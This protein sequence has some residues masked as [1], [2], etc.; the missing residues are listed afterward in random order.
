MK[1]PLAIALALFSCASARAEVSGNELFMTH[2][3]SCHGPQGEGDGPVAAVM[4]ITAPNLRT[5]TERSGGTF[6]ADA[7]ASY[8]DGRKPRAAH[9]TRT[10]PVWGA[11]F[12]DDDAPARS[13]AAQQR[14]AALVAFIRQLQYRPSEPR[15]PR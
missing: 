12:P 5:L 9:G 3:A 2:C 11:L 14:V 8:I 4:A 13:A 6:P 15:Q 7:V 10:M 1:A